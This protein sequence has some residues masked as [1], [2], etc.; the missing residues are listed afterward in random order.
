MIIKKGMDPMLFQCTKINCQKSRAANGGVARRPRH[1]KNALWAVMFPLLLSGCGDMWLGGDG[2]PKLPGERISVMVL[3]ESLK[4]QASENAAADVQVSPPEGNSDWPQFG[5]YS[6]HA[7]HHMQLEKFDTQIW[8]ADI[9]YGNDQ[10]SPLLAA[11]VMADG[12]VYV[13]DSEAEVR[14]IDAETG[15]IVWTLD[16]PDLLG[17]DGEM[18]S[19]GMAFNSG[20]LVA[21]TSMNTVVAIRADTGQVF[22]Q[23]AIASPMRAAPTIYGGR[24]FV[25]TKENIVYALDLR[26]GEQLWKYSAVGNLTSLLGAGVPAA[27][28][29]VVVVPMTTGD[30]VALRANTGDELWQDK[31]AN[32]RRTDATGNLLD[33]LASPLI[34][35]NRVYSVGYSGLMAAH[36]LRSGQRLWVAEV[37]S[38]R[39]PWIAGNTLFTVTIHNEV[40][41]LDKRTGRILWVS[42]LPKWENPEDLTDPIAWTP[43]ILASNRLLIA[44]T[45]EE[46]QVLDPYTG[47][48]LTIEDLPDGVH[49]PLFIANNTLFIQTDDG[50]LRAYR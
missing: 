19:G 13:M 38:I 4:N 17:E 48:V 44:G 39:T 22:W 37:G 33:V 34:D 29:G 50:E 16:L 24:V 7:M 45:N 18:M 5:G 42:P 12:R 21:T 32:V 49:L 28:S 20:L 47:E 31:L 3:E 40:V 43:P 46:L 1:V 6:N 14:A 26:N 25:V 8:R 23:K 10:R 15:D 41:A 11:P 2:G 30:L 35:R 36:D 9:G 27:D